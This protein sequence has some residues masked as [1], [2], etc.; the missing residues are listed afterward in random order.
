VTS[1]RAPFVTAQPWGGGITEE[2]CNRMT[3]PLCNTL[4]DT[5]G[6][7]NPP[8]HRVKVPLLGRFQNEFFPSTT[9]FDPN[10]F[11]YLH[12]LVRATPISVPVEQAAERLTH[13]TLTMSKVKEGDYNGESLTPAMCRWHGA[14]HPRDSR[15]DQESPQAA[16]VRRRVCWAC[17]CPTRVARLGDV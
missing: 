16:R 6:N 4:T 7:L 10:I 9:P 11:F 13:T 15:G 3:I 12:L 1:Q 2:S 8:C 14:D 5:V 17:V